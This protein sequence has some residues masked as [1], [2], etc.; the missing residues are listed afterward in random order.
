M[1]AEGAVEGVVEGA[2]EGVVEG[3]AELSDDAAEDEEGDAR[4][5]V[6]EMARFVSSEGAE[7][8]REAK[9]SPASPSS[10]RAEDA[11]VEDISSD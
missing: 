2:V 5:C 6:G 11:V 9:S 7:S 3:V 1:K 8:V 4:P 10:S